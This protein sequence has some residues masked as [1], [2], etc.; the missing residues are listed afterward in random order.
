MRT[1]LY[2][3]GISVT[4]VCPGGVVTNILK[5]SYEEN[6]QT[7]PDL[8][9]YEQKKSF[10]KSPRCARLMLVAGANRFHQVVVANQPHLIG[11]FICQMFA[12]QLHF[13]LCLLLT[14]KRFEEM[15]KKLNTC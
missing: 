1:E 12:E 4:V 2:H 9:E 8:S 6:N 14:K 7:L 10:M 15:Q 3:T 5:R 11:A 13:L